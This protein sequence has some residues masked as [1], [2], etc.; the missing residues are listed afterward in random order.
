[1][2]LPFTW[3]K[4]KSDPAYLICAREEWG[5]KAPPSNDEQCYTFN[6][7]PDTP[8]APGL[9]P[10]ALTDYRGKHVPFVESSCGFIPCPGWPMT[11]EENTANTTLC[12]EKVGDAITQGRNAGRCRAP[13][14]CLGKCQE[15]EHSNIPGGHGGC[16]FAPFDPSKAKLL[17]AGGQSDCTKLR[18]SGVTGSQG[19]GGVGV[20]DP[21]RGAHTV[22]SVP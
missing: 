22:P 3:A 17:E 5:M 9:D 7:F 13:D 10:A 11:K 12:C 19:A 2:W 15:N 16:S 14:L 18:S 4:L 6:V 20:V 21:C 8:F 1:M